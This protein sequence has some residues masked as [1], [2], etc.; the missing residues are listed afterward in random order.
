MGLDNC[1]K[2]VLA[3]FGCLAIIV[4][5]MSILVIIGMKI[6]DS[7]ENF[8]STKR[9]EYMISH[10]FDTPPLAK[11]YCIDCVH[12]FEDGLNVYCKLF[13]N[14]ICIQDNSFCYR[15]QPQKE[16]K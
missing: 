7:I 13:G 3:I 15:A 2:D 8:I 6:C 14:G 10:R 12:C 4:C 1:L 9:Y 16:R 5:V 11:C